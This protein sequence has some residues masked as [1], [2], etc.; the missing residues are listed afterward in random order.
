MTGATIRHVGDKHIFKVLAK[1][2]APEERKALLQAV[3]AYGVSS[4]QQRFIDQKNP[5]G[6]PWK[7]SRRAATGGGQ[8]LRKS[9]RLFQS[10][11]S[12]ATASAVEW[13]TNVA[14][15][16]IHHFGGV[17]KAKNAKNLMFRGLNGGFTSVK[18]VVI[19]AR[20]YLGINAIDAQR[21]TQVAGKWLD[22]VAQ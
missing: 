12:S 8:T 16:G 3:G 9:T 13:G 1:L 17:I 2:Q 19:P 11:V 4:T 7:K 14:Y 20:P 5:E 18:Q 10:F 21:I 6:L 15:A 22:G